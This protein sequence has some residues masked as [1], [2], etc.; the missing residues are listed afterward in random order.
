[1]ESNAT[2]RLVSFIEETHF[3]SLGAKA[4]SEAKRCILDG[5]GVTLAGSAYGEIAPIRAYVR[6]IGG[7]P[8]ATTI[9]I[10]S[11]R[12]SGLNAAFING[13][14]GHVLDFDDTQIILGGHPTAVLLPSVLGLAEITGARGKEILTALVVGI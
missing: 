2:E 8:Q 11:F 1:M 7:N 13:I 12:T 9:G 6:E 10:D 3:P 14:A 5:L 4:V